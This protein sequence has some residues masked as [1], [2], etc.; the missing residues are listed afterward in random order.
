[1]FRTLGLAIV[2]AATVSCA[3]MSGHQ[4]DAASDCSLAY[5]CIVT[6]CVT[7]SGECAA[8]TSHDSC[9]ACIERARGGALCKLF[10]SRCFAAMCDSAA[11]EARSDLE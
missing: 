11:S 1:M 10:E 9:R 2:F 6:T 8:G 5:H 7:V 4:I 3:P